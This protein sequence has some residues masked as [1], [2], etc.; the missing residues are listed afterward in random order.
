MQ[1]NEE[2]AMTAT[3][4]PEAPTAG[5]LAL[6]ELEPADADA[7]AAIVYDAFAG[8][9]DRHRFPR[10]FPTLD[11]AA[12]VTS[13]FAAH[14]SIWGVVAEV[15]GRVVG[16]NFLDER[17]PIR[18]VGPISVAPGEQ[19]RG[20]G[21]RLMEAVLE[22]GEGARGVRLLQDAFNSQSL[23]LYAS[24][25]F[26]VREPVAVLGGRPRVA[27]G[28]GV[29]VRPLVAGDVEECEAL[30]LRVLGYERTAELRDALAGP[31]VEPHVAVRDGRI[32]AYAAGVTF[33]AASHGVAESERDMLALVLGALAGSGA[34]ASFLLPNR[35]GEL[36][37]GLLAAGLRVVKPMTYMTAGE[38]REPA[39]AWFPSVLY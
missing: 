12:A 9:H 6:R 24:L 14:P 8:I 21:R 30:A 39:G 38:W 5:A 37:R 2:A 10:D 7:A 4:T 36:F 33:F 20:V 15:D 34:D 19:A 18:G 27:P 13:A 22:R 25:G 17:G 32:V 1:T 31:A 11:A 23:A 26:E 35:Q 16:S 28:P 3:P 29:E